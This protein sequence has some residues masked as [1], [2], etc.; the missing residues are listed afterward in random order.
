MYFQAKRYFK[1][2]YA[3]Q[4]QPTPALKAQ[5]FLEK[6]C[7]PYAFLRKKNK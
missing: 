2:H 6:L 7:Q 1:K 3:S 5:I 4:Y